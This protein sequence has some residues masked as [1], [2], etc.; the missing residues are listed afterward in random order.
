[1]SDFDEFAAD[2]AEMLV[3]FM[4][5]TEAVLI[6]GKKYSAAV[7]ALATEE[8]TEF[9]G[10]S[11]RT[12]HRDNCRLLITC[13]PGTV[14]LGSRMT[15]AAYPSSSF[16]VRSIVSVTPT[17]TTVEAWRSSLAKVQSKGTERAS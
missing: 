5:D 8:V 3:E 13:P 12:T 1:M 9:A 11:E 7:G 4:G 15:V 14:G 16:Y 2:S 17:T 10:S 6:D